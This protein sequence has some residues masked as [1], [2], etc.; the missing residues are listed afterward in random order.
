MAK[1]LGYVGRGSWVVGRGS[2]VVGRGSWVVG[3]GMW[4]VVGESHTCQWPPSYVLSPQSHNFLIKRDR[5]I[6]F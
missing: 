4:V 5:S 1:A 2:W 3:R 6:S